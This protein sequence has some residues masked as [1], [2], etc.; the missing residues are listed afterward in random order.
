MRRSKIEWCDYTWNPITGCRY[1]CSYCYARKKSYRFSG[2]IRRNLNSPQLRKEGDL[3]ILDNQFMTE[4]GGTLSYPFG[5][6][7]TLHLYRFEYLD[8]LKNGVNILVGES[9]DMF[10]EW[11]PDEW[12]KMVMDVCMKH[13]R[14]NYFFLTKN[15]E[16]F[17]N[18]EEKGILPDGDNFWYGYSY[19]GNTSQSWGSMFNNKHNFACVEPLLEDLSLFNVNCPPAAEWVIIGA[20][21]GNGKTLVIPKKEWVDKILIHCDK[22]KIPVFIKDSMIP[23]V[24]E[25]NMRRELPPAL[26]QKKPSEKLK[27]KLEGDCFRCGI[28]MKKNEMITLSAGSKRGVQPRRIA[29]MC[30]K[31]FLEFCEE[32]DIK[33]PKLEGV[34][35]EE[36]KLPQDD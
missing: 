2:D 10:G 20:E 24:G 28:H 35:Y 32:S 7:P 8:K 1:D 6:E 21:T 9:G 16:R 18:L 23:I 30:K 31:C 3:Y 4:R 5:F 36:K 34:D 15:P 13:K 19:P 12:I 29:Y 22:Y 11:I 26:L 25:E 14:H 27:A 17:W 33:V